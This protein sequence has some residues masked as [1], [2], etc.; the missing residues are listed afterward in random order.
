MMTSRLHAVALFCAMAFGVT[1]A[2]AQGVQTGTIRGAIAAVDGSLLPG[3]TV[4]ITSTSLQGERHTV[5]ESHG[6]FTFPALP[7]GDYVVDIVM[8]GMTSAR[9]QVALPLGGSADVDVRLEVARVSE[10]VDVTGR[11]VSAPAGPAVAANYRHAEIEALATPRTLTGIA[12]LAP[13]VTQNGPNAQPTEGQGQVVINGALAY[14]NAFLLNGV[15]VNDNIFGWPQNLF[16]EDAIQE[17]QVLTSGISAEYG[18]F[19]GGVI[20]AVT[21][22]GGNTLSGSYRANFSNDAWSTETPYEASRSISRRSRLNTVH[23]FTLGGPVEKD[24]LWFFLSGHLQR[25]NTGATLPYTGT[26]YDTTDSNRRG[27]AK[28]TAT[29]KPGHTLQASALANPREQRNQANF[30]GGLSTIDPAA[31]SDKRRP[32]HLLAA[33]Y[34]GAVSSRVLVE[35]QYSEQ[36]FSTDL[37][38]GTS[39]AIVD[40]PFLSFDFTRQYNAPF[41]DRSDP[42]GRNNRQVTGSVRYFSGSHDLKVGAEWF[43]SNKVG[44]N[45]QSATGYVFFTDYATDGAGAPLYDAGGRLMPMFVPG[46]TQVFHYLA[47]RGAELNVDN[48]SLYAQDHWR[49]NGHVAADLG[50]RIEHVGSSAPATAQAV[51]TGRA[52]PRLALS[53]DPRANGALVVHGTY[54]QYSGRYSD[55]LL[56]AN[57]PVGHPGEIDG[58]YVGPAGQGR[59]FAAGFDPA[60]YDYDGIYASFPSANVSFADDFASPLTHE[61]TAGTSLALGRSGSAQAT[62]IW[63]RTTN[64]IEDYIDL[65]TGTTHIEQ[66]HVDMIVSNRVYANSDTA[67]RAYQGL[68]FQARY[69]VSRD[70]TVSGHWTVQLKNEG[71]YEGEASGQIITSAAG[72]YPEAFTEAQHYP[73]GRLASFQRHKVDVWS[74]YALHFGRFGDASLSGL[75][76]YN[77][78]RVYSLRAANQPLT[79][80]QA[81]MLADVGYVD[82]PSAQSIYY[83][84]PGSES[85]AGYG[86]V[87][88]SAT[89]DVPVVR[90]LRPWVKVDLFNALN[91]QK[92]ISWNTTIRPDASAPRDALGIRTNYVAG[93]L[94]GQPT[95]PGNYPAPFGGQTGGRTLRMAVGFRF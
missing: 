53:V 62:Y 69:P 68:L 32:N 4:T 39:N 1:G 9:R 89:Y 64:L 71:N 5:T 92:V 55:A 66:D 80:I 13:G 23:E 95:G 79:S 86:T 37:G 88:L 24:R 21:K 90:S 83:A 27:E 33:N 51:S 54:G 52:V 3:A 14:D 76:R 42:D 70:W 41:F 30:S 40:S 78:A 65:S 2:F 56:S 10:T 16:V 67:F 77:S 85:F 59:D 47:S 7:A 25:L 29:V 31:L 34:K 74:I 50:V 18:R 36:Q 12:A 28:V 60:N 82:A 93:P 22:S 84:A 11:T 46:A 6:A 17:T 75:W 26:V 94:F 45:G 8:P 43:R 44:G 72:D 63:R 81:T 38:G 73:T 87:D 49:V 35:G 91:N 61:L 20:N 57:S 19:S 48:S 15:D 58:V